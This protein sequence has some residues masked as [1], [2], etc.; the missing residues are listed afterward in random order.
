VRAT[1]LRSENL[2]HISGQATL[3][4]GLGRSYGD[5]SLPATEGAAV[6]SS[7]LADRVLSFHE[8]S[9]VLRAEAGLSLWRLNQLFLSRGWF[10]PVTPGTQYVTL[11]G[12]VAADVH[13]K[14]H[15][16]AGSFG[17]HVRAL[18]LRVASG[19]TVEVSDEQEPE[20]FRATLGGMGMTGHILEVEFS[21]EKIPSPWIWNESRRFSNYEE[22]LQ[23]LKSASQKWPFTVTWSDFLTPGKQR[24]RGI[25]MQGRW[26]EPK[27][28][29]GV[30]PRLKNGLSV[31]FQLPGGV[32][33]RPLG[34][35]FNAIYYWKHG[36]RTR[37]G[38]MHPGAFF[39]PLDLLRN[40][41]RLYGKRGF[42]Q[43][44]CLLPGEDIRVARE[45]LELFAREGGC[46]LL[47]VI[48]DF[49]AQGKGLLSFP[50]PGISLA[51]DLPL[52]GAQTQCL[53]DHLNEYV[54]A[55]G[56]RIYL[57]K[58]ALTQR[59]HFHRMEPR[60]AE[61]QRVRRRWDP[62]ERL[63]SALSRRLLC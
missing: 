44:Q 23:E 55:A 52:R 56:G 43:Y 3:T 47:A 45:F 31:P 24:G 53:V 16:R 29:P 39:Y 54:I 40:W 48:K 51:L 11:G 4:R 46:A 21:L 33:G 36:A 17:E 37:R 42:T 26:A 58:D 12:M 41:N 28:T 60:L 14:N 49:G 57:A 2:H 20:L 32:L 18:R 59:K 27:E 50:S 30:F 19:E 61:W 15:H 13:G 34:R 10:S 35:L 63:E 6:A 22:L 8:P 9:G 38:V 25:L 5:A 1:E 7:V 62:E